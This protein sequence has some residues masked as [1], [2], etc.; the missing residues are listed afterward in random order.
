[1]IFSSK[2]NRNIL[3]KNI[4]ITKMTR[5]YYNYEDF[6]LDKRR[7]EKTSVILDYEFL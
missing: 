3:I 2:V 4:N 6:S 1:M 5:K 7:I